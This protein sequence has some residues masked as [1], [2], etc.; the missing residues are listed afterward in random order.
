MIPLGAEVPTGLEEIRGRVNTP[1]GYKSI[2]SLKFYVG[3]DEHG[4]APVRAE[5]VID[6]QIYGIRSNLSFDDW[7]SILFE[8]QMVGLGSVRCREM[9]KFKV[10]NVEEIRKSDFDEWYEEYREDDLRPLFSRNDSK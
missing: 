6:T 2:V 5:F 1:K 7:V 4:Q 9:G 3:R 8:G 10:M